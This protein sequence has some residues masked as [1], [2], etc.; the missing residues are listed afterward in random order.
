MQ[1]TR[2]LWSGDE[3]VARAARDG[4]VRLGT[5]YPGTPSTEILEAFSELGGQAQWSPNEKVAL[6]VAIGAAFAGARALCTMKHVGL[7]VAADPLFTVA[8]TG[9]VAAGVPMLE[10]ADSQEAYD[11]TLLAIEIS[12]RWQIPVLLRMTTRVC[13]SYTVVRPRP[14]AA[15]PPEPHFERDVAH[16][17][18][19][20][21]YARPAHLRLR[22][23][24]DAIARWN[25]TDG[26][27]RAIPGAS[28]RGIITSG[29][30]YMHVREAAPEASVLKLGMTH[31]LPLG[32]MREFAR[33][34]TDASSRVSA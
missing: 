2:M 19:I 10:P 6:E 27:N 26:P 13:H 15:P 12:E 4:H 24:L 21:A 9:A 28:A 17:V 30:S 14:P 20:P 18:M 34:A 29:I 22:A 32:A 5:G 8:Y 11:F 25:E 1:R 3:A 16:R 31:P 23:K 33:A 7:N